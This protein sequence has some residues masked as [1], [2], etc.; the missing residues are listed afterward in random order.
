[1]SLRIPQ[2]VKALRLGKLALIMVGRAKQEQQGPAGSVVP[3]SST[4]CGASWGIV[5]IGPSYR[6]VSSTT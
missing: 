4:A 2:D 3:P 5:W 1:M 6:R